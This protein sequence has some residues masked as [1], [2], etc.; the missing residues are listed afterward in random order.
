MRLQ[1]QLCEVDPVLTSSADNRIS[2]YIRA[3]RYH[4]LLYFVADRVLGNPG[5]AV[6][7]VENC[8]FWASRHFTTFDHESDFRSWLVR[9]ALDESLAILH[10]REMPE[11]QREDEAG[12]I[13]PPC[14]PRDEVLPDCLLTRPQESTSAPRE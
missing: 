6:I 13:R 10:G 3:A 12:E 2:F 7:A 14:C 1:V 4:R 9:L 5:R 8:L 11:H